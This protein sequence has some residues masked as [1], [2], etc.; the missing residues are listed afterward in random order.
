MR[1]PLLG[2]RP[3]RAA[4]REKRPLTVEEVTRLFEVARERGPRDFAMVTLGATSGIRLGEMFGLRWGDLDL[5][6]DEPSLHVRRAAKELPNGKVELGPPKT[7]SS[8]RRV[9]LDPLALE[10]LRAW[11][12]VAAAV[13]EALVFPSRTGGPMRRS[14][15]TRRV[16]HPL[17]EAADLVDRLWKDCTRVTFATLDAEAHVNPRIVQQVLGHSTLSTTLGIHTQVSA[18][19]A[20]READA[21]SRML[22]GESEEMAPRP[23]RYPA[24][25]ANV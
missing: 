2:V 12:P 3:P 14:N 10:A 13:G 6:G 15:F 11:Q 19:A 24:K 23:R 25:R 22:R 5:R 1:S 16:W 18:R 20:Q 4:V 8:I 17:R 9:P 7:T 21:V